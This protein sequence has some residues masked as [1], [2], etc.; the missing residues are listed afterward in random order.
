MTSTRHTEFAPFVLDLVDFMET[1]DP[2]GS[3]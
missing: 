1:E 3:R 2:N